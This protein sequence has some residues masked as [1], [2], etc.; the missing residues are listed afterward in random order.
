[1]FVVVCGVVSLGLSF[2]VVGCCFVCFLFWRVLFV[3]VDCRMLNLVSGFGISCVGSCLWF[4][5]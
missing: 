2:V 1:M 4:V 5:V 3:V